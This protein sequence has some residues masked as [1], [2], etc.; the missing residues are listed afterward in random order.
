MLKKCFPVFHEETPLSI[1]PCNNPNILLMWK[2]ST[3]HP[4]EALL[5][6]NK[7]PWNQQ[8]F[9][10]DNLRQ[11]IQS[12]KALEDVSPEFQLDYIHQP[13]HYVLRP[14]QGIVLVTQRK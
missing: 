1:L 10:A 7:D 4:D 6:L 8:E 3:R 12:G 13:F 14:G 5:I 11:F 2:A 9:Y